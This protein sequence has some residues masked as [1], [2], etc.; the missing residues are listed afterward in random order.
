MA[1]AVAFYLGIVAQSCVGVL[2]ICCN[3]MAMHVLAS[4]KKL[5][6]SFNA[7]LACNLLLHTLYIVASLA[8]E[9]YK[10]ADGHVVGHVLFTW[11]L[12]PVKPL[13]LHASTVLTVVMARERYN[14][15]NRPLEYRSDETS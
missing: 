5:R 9:A 4:S 12:Y 15:I 8:H 3:L 13:L 1:D 11:L 7:I 2:G 6:S 14:A 10:H